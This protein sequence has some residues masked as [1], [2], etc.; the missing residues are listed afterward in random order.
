[1]HRFS[2]LQEL[3]DS[4]LSKDSTENVKLKLASEN[5]IVGI[6]LM[7]RNLGDEKTSDQDVLRLESKNNEANG[8]TSLLLIP[9]IEGVAGATYHNLAVNLNIPTYILQLANTVAEKTVESITTSIFDVVK[10]QVFNKK[11]F[12]YL[13]GYSFGSFVTLELARQL[14]NAGMKGHV[15]LIDGAPHFLKQLSY[16]HITT[17]LS[18][19]TIQMLLCVGVVQHVFPDESPEDLIS[20][21]AKCESWEDKI[22]F[23]AIYSKKT[24]TQYSEP[25]LRNMMEALYNR[26]KIV[27]NYDVNSAVKIKSSITLVRPTEVAVVDI[28]EDYELSKYTEGSVTLKFLEGNHTTMLDNPKLALI[29]NEADPNLESDREFSTYVWSGKVNIKSD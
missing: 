10:S 2:R 21:L 4:R 14:E 1:M 19:E 8:I 13:V 5:R 29:I 3:A 17:E 7:L 12:F 6:A 18:D 22:D 9:G 16:G 20:A 27:F 23:L 26:L 15:L 24:E 11:E 28:D 25:Y